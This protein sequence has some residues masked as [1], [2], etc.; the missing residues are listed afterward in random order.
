MLNE[1]S[2]PPGVTVT[3]AAPT[4]MNTLAGHMTRKGTVIV[5]GMRLPEF[6]RNRIVEEHEFMTFNAPCKYDMIL[7]ADYCT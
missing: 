7:G 2:L 3:P 5:K 6:K 4:T 1:K